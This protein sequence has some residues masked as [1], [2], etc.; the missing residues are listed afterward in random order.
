LRSLF[1]NRSGSSSLLDRTIFNKIPFK[2]MIFHADVGGRPSRRAVVWFAIGPTSAILAP[3]SA[4]R[5]CAALGLCA[6]PLRRVDGLRAREGQG[7]GFVDEVAGDQCVRLAPIEADAR[8]FHPG[9][10]MLRKMFNLTISGQGR[11]DNRAV[12]LRCRPEVD[13]HR[14]GRARQSARASVRPDALC[15][16]N[17]DGFHIARM[18]RRLSTF[19]LHA[20]NRALQAKT[21][22]RMSVAGKRDGPLIDNRMPGRDCPAE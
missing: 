1:L 4:A 5:T 10:E 16:C 11:D 14:C 17:C 12:G 3:A 19:Q 22:K 15:R 20:G 9:G 18:K 21:E 6:S 13:R 8:E 2:I 7:H